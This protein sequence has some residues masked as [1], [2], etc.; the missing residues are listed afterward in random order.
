[1]VHQYP[2]IKSQDLDTF[3]IYLEQLSTYYNNYM[4]RFYG[5]SVRSDKPSTYYLIFDYH[6]RTLA[7]MQEY[8]Q[9]LDSCQ[10]GTMI[11]QILYLIRFLHSHEEPRCLGNLYLNQIYWP[12]S[13]VL[14]Y[15]SQDQENSVEGDIKLVGTVMKQLL[16]EDTEQFQEIVQLM[17]KQNKYDRVTLTKCIATFEQLLSLN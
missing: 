5:I 3:L 10:V 11:L 8:D 6:S 17:L 16:G 12:M 13:M 1:M 7:Q 9:I 15:L 4:V 14:P 2:S